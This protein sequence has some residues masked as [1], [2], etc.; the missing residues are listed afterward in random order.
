MRRRAF[1]GSLLLAACML[2]AGA[3]RVRSQ[4]HDHGWA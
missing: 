2:M 4:S 3:P 1:M